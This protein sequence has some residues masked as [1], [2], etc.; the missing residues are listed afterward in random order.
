MNKTEESKTMPAPGK[1]YIAP[2]A[3]VIGLLLL[4]MFQGGFFAS[5]QIAPGMLD[6]KVAGQGATIRIEAVSRPD[7][8]QAIG[9]VRSRNEVDIVPRI[10]ARILDIKVRSGDRV[11]A[12][13]VLAV[14]DAKDL[15]AV[16]SQG[17]EQ[18]RAV[19]ASAAAADEQVKSARAA[20]DLATREMERTRALFEKNAAAKRDY[21]Q[22]MTAFRQAEAALQ[23]AIQQRLGATATSAAASQGIKQ[24][25]AGLSY[26]TISARLMPLAPIGWQIRA[27]SAFLP[28]SCCVFLTLKACC[29]KFR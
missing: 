22:S 12:G 28:A 4:M 15:A 23:Q 25:E 6:E 29:L 16:V 11:K 9:T 27:T 26:A 21:D 2:T 7:F 1:S 19:N 13:D 24:A 5:G 14:L 20:L 18:L 17:Q 10:I 3:G 8:Y